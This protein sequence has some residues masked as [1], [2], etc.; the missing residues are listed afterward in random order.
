MGAIGPGS[1]TFHLPKNQAVKA[2]GTHRDGQWTVILK[3]PLY[4]AD[5]A[6]GI[7]LEPGQTASISFAVWD[8]A[9]GDRN[10]QKLVSIWQDL[11]LE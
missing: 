11:K 2:H 9:K 5:A 10:G 3:R 8:G 7:S 4:L 1:T 6:T